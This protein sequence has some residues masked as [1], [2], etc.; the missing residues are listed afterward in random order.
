V[1][2]DIA[3]FK[4]VMEA[5]E[6]YSSGW[7]ERNSIVQVSTQ[8]LLKDQ[9]LFDFLGVDRRELEA[10]RLLCILPITATYPAVAVELLRRGHE[11]QEW[12]VPYDAVYYPVRPGERRR[13]A[14]ANSSGVAIHR[15]R[16]NAIRSALAE[17]AERHYLLEHWCA[18]RGLPQLDRNSLPGDIRTKIG[19]LE[20]IP[21]GGRVTILVH[22]G[23][24]FFG[25]VACLIRDDWPCFHLGSSAHCCLRDAVHKCLDELAN[26]A[27]YC[28]VF[29]QQTEVTDVYDAIDHYCYYHSPKQA[30]TAIAW[31]LRGPTVDWT[32][33]AMEKHE[34]YGTMLDSAQA[35]FGGLA[36]ADLTAPELR[37]C[38]LTAVRVLTEKGLPAWFGRTGIPNGK[39]LWRSGG[40]HLER[41][42]HPLG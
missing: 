29:W 35:E 2:P 6:R 41:W 31:A 9:R 22:D 1:T 36:I 7:I 30:P 5:L 27:L 18:G 23:A 12:L 28:D 39:P 33:M 42:I 38:G 8:S 25:A 26:A 16:E 14:L 3:R 24:T 32:S 4:A 34:S 19:A 10:E 17:Y 20:A 37:V 11:P 40:L 15:T 13:F 21:G